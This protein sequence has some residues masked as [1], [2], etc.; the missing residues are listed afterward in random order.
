MQHTICFICIQP[1]FVFFK[2]L[3][4]VI[5][6][7]EC[8]NLGASL[9]FVFGNDKCVFSKHKDIVLSNYF[10]HVVDVGYEKD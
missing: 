5:N 9:I 2:A 7:S 3:E 10:L 4:Q 8:V 6:F 1:A